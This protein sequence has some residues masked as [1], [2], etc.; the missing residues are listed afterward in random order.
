M[1][2]RFSVLLLTWLAPSVAFAG[3]LE[4]S[5]YSPL[6]KQMA[7]EAAAVRQDTEVMLLSVSSNQGRISRAQAA[8]DRAAAEHGTDSNDYA[9]AHAELE[10]VRSEA[11]AQTVDQLDV[12]ERRLQAAETRTAAQVKGITS[13]PQGFKS[14]ATAHLSGRRSPETTAIVLHLSIRKLHRRCE[15][16]MA[17]AVIGQIEDGLNGIEETLGFLAQIAQSDGGSSPTLENAWADLVAS[18]GGLAEDPGAVDDLDRILS[19]NPR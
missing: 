7:V 9:L 8:A 19:T 6:L 17:Q 2:T 12:A 18:E 1:S 15:D 13:T 10:R 16:L 11:L 4:I 14:L 5:S 3:D